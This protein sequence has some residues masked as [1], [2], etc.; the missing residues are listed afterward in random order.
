MI[1]NILL[2]KKCVAI[3]K[4]VVDL[5]NQRVNKNILNQIFKKNSINVNK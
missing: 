2:Q 5:S 1:S 3:A 4:C